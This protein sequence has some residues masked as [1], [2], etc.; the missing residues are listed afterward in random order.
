MVAL[1]AGHG[2]YHGKRKHQTA[3]AI[4]INGS[5]GM[6]PQRRSNSNSEKIMR[7]MASAYRQRWQQAAA[8][9]VA[10]QRKAM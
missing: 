4:N 3:Q 5:N 1:A 10:R 9:N 8:I 6:A 7:S 2:A